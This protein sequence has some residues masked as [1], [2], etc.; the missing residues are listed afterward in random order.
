MAGADA[1]ARMDSARR[2]AHVIGTESML[3]GVA[4]PEA[5]V[6][7]STLKHVRNDIGVLNERWVRKLRGGAPAELLD[8]YRAI[9][10]ERRTALAGMPDDDW[11]EI[12][13]TPAGPDTYGRF[14]R[15]RAF[16]CWMHEN[17]IR[18]AL[19]RPA[20]DDPAGETGVAAGTRRDG[21]QHGVRRRKAR[22]APD[23][24]RVAL[25]LTGPLQR[26]INVACRWPCAG[27]RGLRGRSR[28]RRSAGRV[29][30]HPAGGRADNGCAA[31]GRRSL[32]RRRGS[33]PRI[34]EHLNY[35][36]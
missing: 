6:D 28:R 10:A 18:D 11:N 33:R 20:D 27:G 5:D 7:V 36:I 8:M 22:G 31:S 4:T 34:V 2:L 35:V 23:G 24:S 3:Q 1:A 12:T 29:A 13:A 21:G 19:D 15:V 14:M 30:V 16:D 25:E 26:T 9:T 17:D 32:R